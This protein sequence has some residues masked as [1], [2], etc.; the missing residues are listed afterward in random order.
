MSS[1]CRR[2]K[3]NQN[4]VKDAKCIWSYLTI[5]IEAKPKQKK[6]IVHSWL[7]LCLRLVSCVTKWCQCLLIIH[8]WLSL[9]LYSVSCVP[10]W[11]Q[12]LLIVYYWLSLCLPPASCVPKWCQC[13]WIVSSGFSN[14]YLTRKIKRKRHGHHLDTQDTRRRQ[15]DKQEWTI[16]RHWHYWVH[17][18]QDEDK[19]TIKN[20]Q[21]RDTDTIGYTRHRTRTKGQSRIKEKSL[22]LVKKISG[23]GPS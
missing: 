4:D 7:S 13:L 3:Q 18:T 17:K 15:R 5:F 20:G 2:T 11:C 8:S 22:L 10:K 16:R 12:C 9:C 23:I 19:G 1:N 14:V 21:S 6:E